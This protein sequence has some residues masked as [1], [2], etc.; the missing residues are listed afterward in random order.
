MLYLLRP[1][2]GVPPPNTTESPVASDSQRERRSAMR[3]L[4][5]ILFAALLL[6]ACETPSGS[7]GEYGADTFGAEDTLRGS[8]CGDYP[9][10]DPHCPLPDIVSG[11]GGE[12][13]PDSGGCEPLPYL[14]DGAVC[15]TSEVG[16]I[17]RQ[18]EVP[19][20][21]SCGRPPTGYGLPLSLRE[22]TSQD[23][24][25]ERCFPDA[26]AADPAAE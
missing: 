5:A 22:G 13:P 6:S 3:N 9:A 23:R 14:Y 1:A 20:T 8:L 16:C 2:G 11:D 15:P 26:Q 19:C 7:D 10:D 25:L 24:V 12:S 4:L 18:G 21:W 17:L